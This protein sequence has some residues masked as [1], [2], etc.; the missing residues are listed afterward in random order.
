MSAL[1][2][3]AKPTHAKVSFALLNPGCGL[4]GAKETMGSADAMGQF[5]LKSQWPRQD[6]RLG[7]GARFKRAR[8]QALVSTNTASVSKACRTPKETPAS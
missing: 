4:G 3:A 1:W 7:M 6:D 2:S 8:F 5:A